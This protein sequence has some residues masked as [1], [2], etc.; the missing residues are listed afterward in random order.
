[1]NR[2]E[3]VVENR[4]SA[5]V[6]HVRLKLQVGAHAQSSDEFSVEAGSSQVIP[7]TVG[8]YA[9]LADL[10]NLATTIE[11]TPQEGEL[12]QI[13]RS[14]QIEVADDKLALR[15][16]NEEFVR[17]G[18]GKVW[19]TLENTGEEEIEIVTATGSGASTPNDIGFSLL[20]ADG[21]VLSSVAY[22]Q[23][24][25]DNVITLPNG[26][27]VARILAGGSFTSQPVEVPIPL[28]APNQVAIQVGIAKINFH[29]GQ[30]DQISIDGLSSTNQISLRD[31]SYYGEV[32]SVAPE[33]STGDEDI[34]IAGDAIERRTGLPLPSVPLNL[35]VSNEKDFAA[36]R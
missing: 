10:T 14:K 8:G 26:N 13:V 31:T 36:D 20:N 2:L 34:V 22:K 4:S 25:G 24:L 6:E 1:M 5:K 35:V 23:N 21:N 27:T 33:S 3:Y 19:F 17:G 9:D 11:V 7:V 29:D 16:F 28:S 30:P 32:L 15:I 12:T 18:L